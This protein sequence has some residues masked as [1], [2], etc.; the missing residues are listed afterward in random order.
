MRETNWFTKITNIFAGK[1]SEKF[2]GERKTEQF[3]DF[4][5]TAPNKLC[6]PTFNSRK[7]EITRR[8]RTKRGIVRE[9]NSRI[10]RINQ[11]FRQLL[12]GATKCVDRV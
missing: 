1:A 9:T 11:I 5:K 6:Q 12:N 8:I 2:P 10:P 3:G 7:Q 4:T